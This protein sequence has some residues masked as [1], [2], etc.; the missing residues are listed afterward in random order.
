MKRKEKNFLNFVPEKSPKLKWQETEEKLVQI[1][2]ERDKLSDKIVRKLFNTPKRSIVSLDEIGS[3][4][5][6]SID[7]KR[8]MYT[9]SK[10][11]HRKLGDK[12]KPMNERLITYIKILKNNGFIYINKK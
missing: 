5:W 12:T 3:F 10:V 6:K 7:G 2:I 8:D 11:M 4:V 1:I 9:I